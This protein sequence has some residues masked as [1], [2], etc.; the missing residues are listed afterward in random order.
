MEYNLIPGMMSWLISLPVAIV[1]MI[2]TLFV[3]RSV[4]GKKNA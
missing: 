3:I 4:T 2:V 1:L